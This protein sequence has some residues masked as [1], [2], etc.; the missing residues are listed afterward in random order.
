METGGMQ[1]ARNPPPALIVVFVGWLVAPAWRTAGEDLNA[2]RRASP[3]SPIPHG[4]AT[5]QLAEAYPARFLREGNTRDLGRMCPRELRGLPG[6]GQ[7]RAV[8]Y[9]RA[10]WGHDPA[11][12]ALELEQVPGI[13][14]ETA[15]RV[16]AELEG[17]R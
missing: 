3:V 1:R 11:L 14:R 17:P 7:V 12:G 15:R 8:E 6:L 13:G 10:R 9:A 4:E 5:R 16:T 2:A